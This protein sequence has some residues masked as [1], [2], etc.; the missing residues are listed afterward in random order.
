MINM[1]FE[2]NEIN[3]LIGLVDMAV[4]TGGL[5]VAKN[6]VYFLDKFQSALEEVQENAMDN[7]NV[8]DTEESTP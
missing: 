4:K 8:M 2:E 1:K 5:S 6:G 7:E 3:A